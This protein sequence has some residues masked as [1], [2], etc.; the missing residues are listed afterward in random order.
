[1]TFTFFWLW[2][3]S[4]LNCSHMLHGSKSLSRGPTAS[5]SRYWYRA[6]SH[7]SGEVRFHSAKHPIRSCDNRFHCSVLAI[8][9]SDA[10]EGISEAKSARCLCYLVWAYVTAVLNKNL[11]V[12]RCVRRSA[13]SQIQTWHVS[14][15]VPSAS[16][17]CIVWQTHITG[18]ISRKLVNNLM[19]TTIR[20]CRHD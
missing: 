20:W 10:A 7:F 13:I 16:I 15:D 1:M 3:L 17:A 12:K 4:R 11:Q 9:I 19:K 14:G 8:G 2:L 18:P 5:S 6:I